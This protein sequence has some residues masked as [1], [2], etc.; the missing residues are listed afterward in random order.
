MPACSAAALRTTSVGRSVVIAAPSAGVSRAGALTADPVDPV[1][2]D[3]AA[4]ELLVQAT[5]PAELNGL[6]LLAYTR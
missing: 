3:G 2:D 4:G 1:V 6:D 5:E